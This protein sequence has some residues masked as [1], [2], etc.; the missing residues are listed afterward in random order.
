MSYDI[1]LQPMTSQNAINILIFSNTLCNLRS[2][3]H[4]IKVKETK[5]KTSVTFSRA[6][7]PRQN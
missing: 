3:S 5:I 4:H 6:A 1:D 7:E 2:R